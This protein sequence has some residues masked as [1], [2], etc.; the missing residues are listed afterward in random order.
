[1]DKLEHTIIFNDEITHKKIQTLIE[2]VNT[3]E[4]VN[5]YFATNGGRLS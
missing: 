3:Y 2:Y 5:L 1:M 4:F